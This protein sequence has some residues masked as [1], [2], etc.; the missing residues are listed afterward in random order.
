VRPERT[1]DLSVP[2]LEGQE[3]HMGNVIDPRCI[4]IMDGSGTQECPVD[5]IYQGD[6]T[7]CI[8]HREHIDPG[9]CEPVD[10]VGDAGSHRRLAQQHTVARPGC[11]AQV[12]AP[13]GSNRWS[14]IGVDTPMGAQS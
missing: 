5:R 14:P 4:D 10:L 8:D 9:S 12:A 11:G 7:V 2:T 6:R 1:Y 13:G 3:A